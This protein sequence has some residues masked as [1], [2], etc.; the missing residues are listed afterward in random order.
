MYLKASM[1]LFSLALQLQGGN[2]IYRI[3]SRSLKRGMMPCSDDVPFVGRKIKTDVS[4]VAVS[5]VSR[6]LSVQL[7]TD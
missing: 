3:I 4:V 5:I 6:I 1:A 7:F 2:V